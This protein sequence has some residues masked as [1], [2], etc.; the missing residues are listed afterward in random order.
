MLTPHLY[1]G[2]N[3]L[4]RTRITQLN[5]LSRRQRINTVGSTTLPKRTNQRQ[6]IQQQTTRR[7]NS[8]RRTLSHIRHINHITS[9][10]LLNTTIVI[11]LSR[12]N[13]G[14]TLQPRSVLC[15]NRVFPHRPTVHGSSGPSRIFPPLT[16]T[17]TPPHAPVSPPTYDVSPKQ[18]TS[19]QHSDSL[20]HLSAYR[21]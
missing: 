16:G 12:S 5:R 10:S 18:N 11:F 14:T 19:Y 6:R 4:N 9:L 21:P 13:A 7:I 8:S 15:N 2:L 17:N 20:Y 3:N 1:H